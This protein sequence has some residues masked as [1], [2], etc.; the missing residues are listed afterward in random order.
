MPRVEETIPSHLAEEA[1]AARAWFSRDRGSEFKLT[2]ILDP[3]DPSQERGAPEREL[4]LI[5]C[6]KENGQDVCLRE[7]FAIAPASTGFDVRHL[8][9]TA[10][11][12]GSPAPAPPPPP[13][14]RRAPRPA[15]PTRGPYW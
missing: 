6:G 7:R 3:E 5:L 1:E 15:L 14:R 4:Q 8:A 9:D 2:G 12:P 11:D 13:K 10:P